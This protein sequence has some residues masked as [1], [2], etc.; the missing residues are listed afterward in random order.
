M[1]RKVSAI[2]FCLFLVL[3]FDTFLSVAHADFNVYTVANSGSISPK[4]SFSYDEIPWLYIEVPGFSGY[5]GM[6]PR[7]TIS[8]GWM[9]QGEPPSITVNG[10]DQEFYPNGFQ[11]T[12]IQ[13]SEWDSVKQVGAWDIAATYSIYTL[14]GYTPNFIANG[15]D[16][17]SFEVTPIPEPTSL[18]L[19][20]SGLIGIFGTFRRKFKR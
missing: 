16:F 19:L 13:L 4:T 1:G 2:V 6:Y 14:N 18:M 3:S 20:G 11:N 7:M 15:T 12:W 8:A 10:F 5:P 17:S 9:Y